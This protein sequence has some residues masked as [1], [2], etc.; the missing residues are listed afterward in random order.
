MA[1]VEEGHEERD[2]GVGDD[3]E[4]D[5]EEKGLEIEWE[6]LKGG[7]VLSNQVEGG[8]VGH[9]SGEEHVDLK[10]YH[11]LGH[12]VVA[13][14]RDRR[15]VGLSLGNCDDSPENGAKK[16]DDHRVQKREQNVS[17][18]DGLLLLEELLS[19]CHDEKV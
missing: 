8:N 3:Q 18:L 16:R 10:N 19:Q 17:L 12:L 9:E 2:E 6:D 13:H 11:H 14:L 4:E 7:P 5:V 15:V 1:V